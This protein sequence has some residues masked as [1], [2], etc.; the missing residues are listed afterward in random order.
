M[1]PLPPPAR[2]PHRDANAARKWPLHF[3]PLARETLSV[4]ALIG[5]LFPATP[6]PA[7]GKTLRVGVYQNSPKVFVDAGGRAR[8]FF[9]DIVDEI[10]RRENWSVEYVPG[11]WSEN[12]GR[13]E[14]GEIDM[15]VDVAYSKERAEQFVFGNIFVLDS[16]LDVFSPR[17]V[18]IAS[19]RDLDKKRIAV[20]EGS[21]QEKYLRDELRPGLGI[22]FTLLPY[23]D[24]PRSVRAVKAGEADVMVATRFYSFSPERDEEMV[25]ANVIFRPDNLYLAFPRGTDPRLISTIDRHVASMKNEPRSAYYRALERWLAIHP[26]PIVPPYIKATLAAI[27]GL[28]AM[29]GLF[30]ILLRRQVTGRTRRL[31]VSHDK[32]KATHM[33]LR[34]SERK[35]RTLFE[36]SADGI[37]LMT[38][39]FTD[40]NEQA[41]R[42]W[43]C[44]REDIVGH[45]PA[46]FSP[47]LQPDGRPSVT[48]A[49]ERIERALSGE[50]QLFY[51]L[52]QAKD[53]TLMDTEVSLKA[54]RI[55]G[56][57]FL[58]ATVRDITARKRAE[59]EL[60]R[61]RCRLEEM[62]EQRTSQLAESNRRLEIVNRELEAFSYSA[63]HDLRAPLRSM[64]GFSLA[65][66]ED[67]GGVLD[68]KARDYLGRI[69]KASRNMAELIDDLLSLSRVTRSEMRVVEVDMSA[70]AESILSG[71]AAREPGRSVEWTVAPGAVARGDPRLLQIAM[72]NL[73]GNAWKFTGKQPNAR[74][75]FGTARTGGRTTFFVRDNG[76]GF[77]MEYAGKLFNPFQR[78]HASV[79]FPGTGIGLAIVQRIIHRHGGTVRAEGK[80][81]EGAT[82]SFTL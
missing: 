16:W 64:E 6:S 61:Y 45:S 21:V 74:I 20:L 63:S 60:E 27:T 75:E 25:P 13:L 39:L 41:C 58:M 32:L 19:L 82:F 76:A 50:P 70:M 79:D 4:F 49:R 80:P 9:V 52:H 81:G 56:K 72:E 2:P 14:K 17:G 38:D 65:L 51:W 68:E 62:V 15:L 28:L 24:Y 69:R 37:F 22:D 3:P 78:L 77:D 71:L 59:E 55:H 43:K 18:H 53:G 23:P 47:A 40:C 8:G 44:R 10:A 33:A 54:L 66:L 42:L 1:T 46:E 5:I 7:H 48:A 67:Y 34:D 73:L 11:T 31:R 30:V 35:Y 26:E 36:G 29:I 12:L 57:T